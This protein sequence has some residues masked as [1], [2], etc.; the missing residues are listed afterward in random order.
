MEV[1]KNVEDVDKQTKQYEKQLEKKTS[2]L[3]LGRTSDSPSTK[4]GR[5]KNRLDS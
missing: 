5:I 1:T 2:L 4:L 3:V